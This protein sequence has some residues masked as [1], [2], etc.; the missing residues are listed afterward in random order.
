MIGGRLHDG[1]HGLGLVAESFDYI[2]QAVKADIQLASISMDILGC[3]I[4]G[5]PMARFIVAKF[6]RGFWAW[7]YR[8]MMRM[9]RRSLAKRASL[10]APYLFPPCRYIFGK[11]LAM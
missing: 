8:S 10:S 5:N 7:R 3:F 11:M 9:A 4:G 6:K 1:F 2:Y